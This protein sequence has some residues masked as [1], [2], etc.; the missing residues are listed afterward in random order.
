ML[1]DILS[2]GLTVMP[3]IVSEGAGT[4]SYHAEYDGDP[5]PST[6]CSVPVWISVL[7][8][9]VQPASRQPPP[10]PIQSDDDSDSPLMCWLTVG[11]VHSPA[12]SWNSLPPCSSDPWL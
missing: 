6:S 8:P 11:T 3:E 10:I 5:E 7:S 1:A 2:P 4:S 12:M 9:T